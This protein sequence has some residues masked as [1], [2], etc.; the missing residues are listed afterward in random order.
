LKTINQLSWNGAVR[1]LLSNVWIVLTTLLYLLLDDVYF[2][3]M[4][5]PIGRNAQRCAA[6]CVFCESD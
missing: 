6:W 5:L 4:S 1:D 3:W 2:Q